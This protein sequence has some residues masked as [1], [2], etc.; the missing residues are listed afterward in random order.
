MTRGAGGPPVRVTYLIGSL[1]RGGAERQLV[2]LVN[3]L[4][5]ERF[6]PT[7]LTWFGEGELEAELAP[8]VEHRRITGS[9]LRFSGPISRPGLAL[10]ITARLVAELRSARPHLLHA[11]LFTAYVLAAFAGRLAGVPAIVAGRRG[12]NTY[13]GFPF[14]APLA[15]RLANTLIDLH[16]CNSGAVR[17]YALAHESDLRP[18]RVIVIRNGFASPA[19]PA[20]TRK[21]AER[22]RGIM[23]ANFHPY[24]DHGT[25][26]RG[27]AIARRAHP[28]LELALVG[29]GPERSRA[30]DLATELGLNGAVHFLGTRSDVPLLLRD[31]DFAVLTSTEEGFPNAVMEAM[32]AGIPVVST[33]VGGVVELIRDGLDGLLVPSGD[34]AA[35]AAALGRLAADPILRR[36]LGENGSSRIDSEF[37][38]SRMVRETESA[39][40]ELLTRRQM[41]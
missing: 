33:A 13:D 12:L 40:D 9:R 16:I 32:A 39:Y 28:E 17:S 20:P 10:A 37:G 8:D 29:S 19:Q 1:E 2:N 6:R 18:D 21:G 14:P 5:R 15:G 7:I 41:A 3:N 31:S 34:A 22:L 25:A 36:R 27:L 24:K 35:L 11:Y 26:L 30:E 23:V 38:V 4:D